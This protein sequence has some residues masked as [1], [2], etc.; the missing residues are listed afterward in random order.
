LRWQGTQAAGRNIVSNGAFDIW[1]RGTS[2]LTG[3]SVSAGA[4][5]NADRWQN[6]S[7]NSITISRQ[8]TGD[9]TNLPF[10]QYC[11]RVQRNSGQTNLGEVYT[12]QSIETANSLV[13]AGRAVT[14]SFYARRGANFSA[15]SNVFTSAIYYGTGTDQN[16]FS[17]TGQTVLVTGSHTLTTTWQR[18][19]ITATM[20]VTATEIAPVFY[21]VPTGTAGA[22]DFYEITGVQL[23]LGSVAT[24]FTRTGGT[25]QGEL[26]ACQRYYIRTKSDQL[27]S[28]YGL[29]FGNSTTQTYFQVN[30]PEMRVSPTTLDYTSLEASDGSAAVA[31]TNLTI[32]AGNTTPR[33]AFL[34]GTHSSGITQYRPYLLRNNAST[35]GYLGLGAEL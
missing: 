7:A 21:Y 1:Q 12:V 14:L 24:P 19:Q 16:I 29:G 3:N 25:L 26:A 6:Y 5:Y 17:Y 15:A 23:E 11:A 30:I 18:F 33:V 10:I 28:N 34:I 13:L 31:F 22:N 9:T 4:G 35:A 8:A 32:N 20:P 27:S 2:G